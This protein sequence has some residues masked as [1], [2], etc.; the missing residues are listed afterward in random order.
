[1]NAAIVKSKK[2]SPIKFI[3]REFKQNRELYLMILPVLIYFFVFMYIPM[4]GAS[5]AFKNFTPAKGILGSEWIGFDHFVRFFNSIY[6][7]RVLKNTFLLS[8]ASLGWGFPA[9][10]ILALLLNE[11][12]TKWFKSTVQTITYLPH[13]ISLVVIIG[14]LKQFSVSTG[15]FNDII[16]FFG[17]TRLPLLQRPEY[18]R[19]LYVSSEIWQNIG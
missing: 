13:F 1:M 17:A 9:P 7:I 16:E 19:L 2:S 4:Y 18:F 10:I 6:F 12:R 3:Q 11:I 15:L 5:I 14:L 8:L